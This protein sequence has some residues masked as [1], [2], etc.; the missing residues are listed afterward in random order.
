LVIFIND[1]MQKP[2]KAYTFTGGTQIRFSEP[3]ASGSSLQVLFYRGT[4]ADVGTAQAVET[5]MKGDIVTINTPPSNTSILTQDPRT[6]RETVSRDTLQTT[7]YKGQGISD[8]KNPQRPVTWRKQQH[9][10]IIDGI[11]VSKARGLYAGQ[12]FPASNII[13]DVATTDTVVYAKGGIVAFTKTEDPNTTSFGVR[14]VDTNK[15]NTGFGTTGF[16]N[17]IKDI[18]GATLDG[19]YGDVVGIGV[20]AKGIQFEFSIPPNSVLRDNKFGGFTETG[21]GTGDYFVISRSTIG[22]GVTA[23]S[24][25]GATTIGI[26]TVAL[27]GVFQVSDIARVGSGQTIRVSTEIASGHGINAVGLSS[28]FDCFYGHYS[29]AKFS[30]GTVGLAFTANTLNGLT[31]LTTAPTI[32][33]STKLLLDYT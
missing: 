27:D 29:W 5:I 22:N 7:I 2:G 15:N 33:R 8:V 32:Q 28:G 17:P 11:K 23:K 12:V 19:D 18:S 6:I 31:G 13:A 20:T 30:T 16:I 4:D 10:K 3:P 26:T 25:N 1:V 24:N 21:I 14:I 9:D